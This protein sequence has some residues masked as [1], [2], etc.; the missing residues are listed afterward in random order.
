MMT[1]LHRFFPMNRSCILLGS[2]L[3]VSCAKFGIGKK[4]APSTPNAADHAPPPM[5]RADEQDT[6]TPVKPPV[7]GALQLTPEEDI[8]FTNPDD[9]ESS[10]PE[11]S[12]ILSAAPKRRGPWEQSE[13]VARRRAA[14]EGKPLLI[15]FTDSSSSSPMC[16]ALNE[17]LFS[18]PE[19]EKWATEKLIRLRVDADI[20]VDDAG[21]SLGE[22]ESRRVDLKNYV[23]R[24]KKQYK[25]L[26]QPYLILLDPGGGVIGRYPGYKRGNA[27]FTWGLI[28]QGEV[29]SAHA[30][31]TWRAALEKKGYREW[32]D[33]QDRKVFAR[34]TSYSNGS[35][36]LIEPDG[37]R[38]RTHENKLSNADREWISDQKKIRSLQ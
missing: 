38:S 28:K 6:G 29:A 26:G 18:A 5:L 12:S 19:F 21:L 25:V 4:P 9:P 32:R 7:D 35:L 3:L 31:R 22:K 13:S 23:A 24:L 16:K 11:L 17:E 36:I 34:L 30:H 14:R 33:R 1:R 8:V 10:L 20:Q 27:D 15:W 37:T 2:L